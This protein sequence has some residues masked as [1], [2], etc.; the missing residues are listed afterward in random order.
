[1]I[2]YLIKFISLFEIKFI[3]DI[4]DSCPNRWIRE[5]YESVGAWIIPLL[6]IKFKFNYFICNRDTIISLYSITKTCRFYNA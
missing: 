4:K 6:K 5:F 1:M 2:F 3:I